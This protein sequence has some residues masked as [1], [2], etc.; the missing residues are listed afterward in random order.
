MN[1]LSLIMPCY[2]SE[3]YIKDA[4]F[5]ILKQT[6]NDFQFIIIDD[7]STDNTEE[8]VLSIKIQEFCIKKKSIRV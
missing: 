8:M 6:F 1:K 5:S 2:N 3:T 7:G 4:I